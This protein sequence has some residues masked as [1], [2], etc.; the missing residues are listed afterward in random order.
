MGDAPA[1]AASLAG[2]RR[3]GDEGAGLRRVAEIVMVLAAAGEVRGGREPT[4]AERAL[5]AEA[6]E[7][8][9]AAVA[10]GAVR[11]KDLFPGEAVRAVVEDLGLNRA[12]DPA[13]MGFRPPKASIADRLMLTKR[14]ME[15]VKEAPVQPT[16]S[17][18]QTAVST[19]M[20]EFHGFNGASKFG[21]GVP[22][23]PQVAA[24][25]ATSP[26][27]S[28]SPVV[29]KPPG[30][31]PVKPVAN[32]SGVALPHTGPSHL[33]LD[34][35]VNGPLNLTRSGAA[36]VH[37]NKST[38]DTSARS[39]VN[40][41]QSSNQLLKNQD[42]KPVAVQAA[43]GNTV[44][45]HRATPGVAFV[46]P[47]PTFVNHNDIAKTVQ[48]FL[49]QPANH[50]SWTPPSTEYMHS[51]LG[52]QICKVAITDTDSLLVCDAC[53][54]GVHLK[55]LQQYGNKGV[56]K[57][58]WHCS[59]CLTQ[60]KG[61]PLPPKYGKVTRT[62]VASKAAPPGGGAQVSLPGSAENMA[63]KENH[64]KLAA[65]GNLMKPISIQGGSTVHNINVLALSAITAGSQ[66]QLA[67]TLRPPIGN[68]VKAETSSNGKEGTGQQCSSML[69]PDVKPPPD[70]KL[71]SGSSLNSAGSANDIMNSEQTAE[72]SGA[73]AK[74]KSE[75]NSDPPLSRN[76][77]LVD[78]SG[79]SVEQTKIVGSEEKPSAQATSETDKMKDSETT[80]NTGTSLDQRRNFATEEK[81]LSEAT[82]EALTI[83]AVKMT[84]TGIA[85]E[86]KLQT[87]AA[88]DPPRI[89][90]MEM[91]T[92]NGPPADQSINLV[93]E[94][95]SQS[96]QTSS[97]GD[98]DVT[99][100]AGIPTDQTQH[101]NGSTEN[102]VKKPPNGEPYKDML[103]CNIVSDYVSTQKVASNGILHP[104][105][106]TSCVH[107][108]E[109]VGCNTEAN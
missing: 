84:S 24:V 45:G 54:R 77:E 19:G 44:V 6:R 14:K 55:C 101:S 97:I 15:E 9:A 88:S 53:E 96:E 11:P 32:S 90:D 67:S 61:K 46:P 22:R 37:P 92:N 13:A 76:E 43:T 102:V 33:K 65:N 35:D 83:N 18:P 29:L 10:E 39:N 62:V 50:P 56:P 98:T 4:A 70:K 80:A 64:Q 104:K 60:S 52:C 59:A 108:N 20:A 2:K 91:G 34:K 107:E 93:A 72:I 109:A 69:Q 57:A 75:A 28:T 85:I 89:Q 31:S 71:R 103:G 87:D 16:V 100:N 82:S 66:S 58:E 73:E 40:A 68:T 47:K 26:L 63:A 48:Q 5:A 25:A 3:R 17:T 94:E 27:T 41:V 105:D 78:S 23:N 30:S 8:L 95:K 86:E 36:V 42:T 12:K 21:V 7:R 49:H 81:L 99:A 38:L 51:R 106:E 1:A 79:T 74:I